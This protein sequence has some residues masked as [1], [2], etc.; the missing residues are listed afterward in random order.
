M[1]GRVSRLSYV[2][3]AHRSKGSSGKGVLDYPTVVYTARRAQ[4][5]D[6]AVAAILRIYWDEVQR[7]LLRGEI[8]GCFG[9]GEMYVKAVKMSN[10]PRPPH[11]MY[12]GPGGTSK[13]VQSYSISDYGFSVQLRIPKGRRWRFFAPIRQRYARGL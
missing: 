1:P 11:W 8:V 6:K 7:A 2:A 13:L 5:K 10:G 4:L 3:S 12:R 9:F